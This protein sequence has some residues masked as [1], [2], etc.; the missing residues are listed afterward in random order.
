MKYLAT[1]LGILG[2]DVLTKKWAK[3]NLPLGEKKEIVKNKCYLWH[4][5]ND[6]MAYHTFAGKRKEILALTGGIIAIYG[7]LL[8][9]AMKKEEERAYRFPLVILLAGAVGNFCE[10]WKDGKVTDFLFVKG[11]KNAP[12]FNV[13]DVAVFFGAFCM[14]VT[15]LRKTIAETNFK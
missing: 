12:I 14:L 1:F 8:A 6:G 7:G 2:L 5:K 9:G 15:N 13:A 11:G 3:E 4:I 10:R